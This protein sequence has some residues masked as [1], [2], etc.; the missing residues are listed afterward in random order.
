[1]VQIEESDT[2]AVYKADFLKS[3]TN[4]CEN[5]PL[6]INLCLVNDSVKLKFKYF[7]EDKKRYEDKEI[8]YTIDF[9]KSKKDNIYIIKRL[10]I[11]YYPLIEIYE[12]TKLSK[13]EIEEKVKKGIPVYEALKE[14]NIISKNL[15]KLMRLTNE[16]NTIECVLLMDYED[17]KEGDILRFEFLNGSISL[18]LSKL[19]ENKKEGSKYFWNTSKRKIKSNRNM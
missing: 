3:F 4:F 10:M 18:F 2:I 16:T 11:P 14:T 6:M 17:S 13:E 15:F 19:L 8:S 1:M 7:N 5:S 12:Q 9:F